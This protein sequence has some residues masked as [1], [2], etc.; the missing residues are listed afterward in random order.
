LK[1]EPKEIILGILGASVSLAGLLLVFM[2]FV[3]SHSENFESS[4]RKDKYRNVSKFGLL[5]FIETLVCA[6]LCI[7]WLTGDQRVYWW[8]LQA[9]RGGILM[10]AAY[11]VVTL[12]WYL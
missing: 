7:C 6:W 9:F 3:Y 5:P 1:V 12:L 2:G 10:T 4:V 11:G 8:A